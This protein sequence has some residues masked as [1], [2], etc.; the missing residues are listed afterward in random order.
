MK[1]IALVFVFTA[2]LAT[3]A[4]TSIGCTAD[5]TRFSGSH[6]NANWNFSNR[7]WTIT[8]GR[9]NGN[10]RRSF[11]IDSNGLN[12]FTVTSTN[13]EGTIELV[14]TQGNIINR[15]NIAT[16]FEQAQSIDM[17]DFNP[18]TRIEIRLNFGSARN[19]NTLI[20]WN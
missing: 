1:K 17:S 4:I 15:V 5:A 16:G 3:I 13:T 19:V 2:I 14:L 6:S 8:A 9:I 18:D 7:T 11:D 20:S 10:L 12:T